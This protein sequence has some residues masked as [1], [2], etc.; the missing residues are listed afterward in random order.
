VR[1]E[2]Q[3]LPHQGEETDFKRLELSK[4]QK[5]KIEKTIK[6]VTRDLETEEAKVKIHEILVRVTLDY[7]NVVYHTVN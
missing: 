7:R 1:R 4:N 6:E 2:T 5:R 3:I